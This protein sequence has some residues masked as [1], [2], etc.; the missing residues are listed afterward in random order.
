MA[1]EAYMGHLPSDGDAVTCA[2]GDWHMDCSQLRVRE[3]RTHD[4]NESPGASFAIK[5]HGYGH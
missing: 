2:I 4:A 5:G 3:D 1:G